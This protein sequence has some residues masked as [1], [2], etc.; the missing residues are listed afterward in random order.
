MTSID[1][2]GQVALVTGSSQGIGQTTAETLAKA[3]AKVVINFFP[4]PQG[5][6]QELA[7]QVVEG[8]G[9]SQN[10]IAIGSDVRSVESVAAMYDQAIE[11][12]GGVDIVVNNAGILR[13]RSIK[14]MSADEW[15]AVIDTNLT[16]VF[17]SCQ[18]AALKI[19]KG[20]R[21]INIA[22]LSA[23]M[24]F[25]GQA[26]YASAKSGVLGLTKVL[27]RELARGNVRVNAVAPGVVDTEM[28]QSIPEENRKAMMTQI[29]LARFAEPREIADVALFLASDLSSYMTGQTLH[30]NGGWWF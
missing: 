2:S 23:V 10:A 30:V 22:S 4:D 9:G 14:K 3:G 15:K 26:N 20:G 19:N 8:L 11:Q 21:I 1:L 29:P 6:N 18:Q 16:G 13:D 25:F 5:V 17:N 27:A 12:F 28:G 7:E 24:G